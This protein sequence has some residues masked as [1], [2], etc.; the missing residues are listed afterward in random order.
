M[1]NYQCKKCGTLLQSERTP[2]MS[3]C[4]KGSSHNW[5]NVGEAGTDTYQCKKCDLM[6]KSKNVPSTPGCISGTFHQWNKLNR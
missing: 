3:G 1:K 4:Q 6:L 5:H 2:S